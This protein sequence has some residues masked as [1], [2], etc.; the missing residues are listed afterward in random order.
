MCLQVQGDYREEVSEIHAD[1]VVHAHKDE[2]LPKSSGTFKVCSIR[3]L[4]LV[5]CWIGQG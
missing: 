1:L 5:N 2:K 4:F 3:F